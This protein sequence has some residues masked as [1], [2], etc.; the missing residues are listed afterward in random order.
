MMKKNSV[1]VMLNVFAFEDESNLKGIDS[2][3]I[4]YFEK[5]E[6]YRNGKRTSKDDGDQ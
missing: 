3:V 2:K 5:D 6:N 4:A 1:K